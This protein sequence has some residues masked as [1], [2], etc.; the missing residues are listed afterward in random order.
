MARRAKQ[1]EPEFLRSQLV[2]LL[3]NFK[4]CLEQGNIREQV[5]DLVPAN[6]LLRDLGS[7]LI[8]EQEYSARDR[9]IYYLKEYVGRVVHGGRTDGR[10]W[11]K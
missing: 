3:E 10:S 1:R 6:Y 9:I 7:S 4:V 11:N 8:D 5:L 2:E